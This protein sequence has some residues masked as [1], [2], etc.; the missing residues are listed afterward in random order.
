MQL[1]GKD[2]SEER[3]VII[4]SLNKNYLKVFRLWFHFFSK[5]HLKDH[6]VVISYDLITDKEL[7]RIGVQRHSL[8]QEFDLDKIFYNRLVVIESYLNKGF[9]VIH[10]DLDAFWLKNPLELIDYNRYDLAISI[11][12]GMPLRL[13]K[14][15]GFVMCCGFFV[16]RS[17][18]ATLDLIKSWKDSAEEFDYDDQVALN[19]LMENAGVQWKDDSVTGTTG[20][21]EQLDIEILVIEYD[22]VARKLSRLDVTSQEKL[23][24][25]HP[26][27]HNRKNPDFQVIQAVRGLS[28]ITHQP[29]LNF[30]IG[31]V[32][33]IIIRIIP[34]LPG[35]IFRLFKRTIHRLNYRTNS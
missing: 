27:F 15:W 22:L 26:Y 2:S 32:A 29:Y 33:G 6:L 3:F 13:A 5:L 14:I 35:K 12:H 7:D 19:S 16:L 11:G 34:Q 8:G 24:I 10:T 9:N 4:A 25:Y 30:L 31:A 21:C 18:K 28:K 20:Y 17:N 23:S 1:T